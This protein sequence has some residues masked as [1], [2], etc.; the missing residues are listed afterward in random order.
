MRATLTFS[1]PSGR[2]SSGIDWS[3][4]AAGRAPMW[5]D[6]SSTALGGASAA[7]VRSGSAAVRA[8]CGW[9]PLLLGSSPRFVRALPRGALSLQESKRGRGDLDSVMPIEERLEGKDLPRRHSR[10]EH[11][12]QLTAENAVTV[13]GRLACLR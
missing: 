12:C 4:S 11:A 1:T 13:A 8:W 6:W 9:L 3:P 7:V 5:L 10:V 2:S